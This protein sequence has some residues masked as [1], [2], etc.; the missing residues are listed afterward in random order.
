MTKEEFDR[1]FQDVINLTSKYWDSDMHQN[2][3]EEY[4]NN[5]KIDISH[6]Y[7]LLHDESAQYT[8]QLVY[9][10]LKVLLVDDRQD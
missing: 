10:A 6:L 7:A 3:I 5:G 2:L 4:S 8:N 9:N 1:K